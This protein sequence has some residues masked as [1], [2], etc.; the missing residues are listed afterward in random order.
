MI[1]MGKV[2][3]KINDDRSPADTHGANVDREAFRRD[4]TD[5]GDR[6]RHHWQGLVDPRFS[7]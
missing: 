5:G 2:E 3:H 6:A 1:K 4:R 7:S